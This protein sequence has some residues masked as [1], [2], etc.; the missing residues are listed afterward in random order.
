MGGELGAAEELYRSA[1]QAGREPQ[2]GLALLRVAQGD[3]D[4]AEAAIRRVVA[5]TSGRGRRARVLG[6]Y[7]AIMLRRGDVEAAARGADELEEISRGIGTDY[8]L[9]VSAQASGAVRL[10]SGTPAAALATLRTAWRLWRTLDAPYEAAE[11]RRL[12]AQACTAMGDEDTAA[13]EL[14]AARLAFEALG[15]HRDAAAA[16]GLFAADQQRVGGLSSREIEVIGLIAKGLSNREIAS[17]L[18]ISEHTVARHVQ[19][20]FA[21]LGVTSRA[22]AGSFAY[23]HGLVPR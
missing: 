17:A 3:L 18:I 12:I 23:E 5:E 21:K 11:T 1:L 9:A 7:V 14:D 15:A 2:P 22:A 20:I 6:P 8:A 10:A 4:A 13:M 16:T 19:N